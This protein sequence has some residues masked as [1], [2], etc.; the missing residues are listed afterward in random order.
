DGY[1]VL[2]E[3][4]YPGWEAYVDGERVKILRANYLFRAI[5]LGSGEHKVKFIFSPETFQIG[6]ILSLLGVLFIIVAGITVHLRTPK[7]EKEK[8]K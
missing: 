5:P 4:Y 2:S 8:D 3:H 1:L 6:V 7:I